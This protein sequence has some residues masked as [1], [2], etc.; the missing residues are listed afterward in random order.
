MSVLKRPTLI[1]SPLADLHELAAELALEGYRKLRKEDLVSAILRS[2]GIEDDG[3]A[4]SESVRDERADGDAAGGRSR[5]DG[6]RSRASGPRE[7]PE[8]PERSSRRGERPAER[9][10]GRGERPAERGDDRAERIA[11][12][13]VELSGNGSG[14]L[15]VADGEDV[16]ISAAQVRRCELVDGDEVTGPVR[17]ARRSERHPSLARVHSIN[18]APSEEVAGAV[19]FEELAVE[20]PSERLPIAGSDPVLAA[21]DAAVPIGKGSRVTICGAPHAGKS[22]L[23]REYGAALAAV[24]GLSVAIVLA[25]VRPEEIADWPQGED[26]PETSISSDS[27]PDVQSA[28]VW[29]AVQTGRRVAARGGDAVVLIDSLEALPDGTARRV[30][31]SARKLQAGGSLT[32][33]AT[34]SAPVGLETSIIALD[35]AKRRAGEDPVD[36]GGS[37]TIA[38]DRLVAAKP[39]AKRAARKPAAAKK[40]AAKRKP[41][42]KKKAAAKPPAADD[43]GP[44]AA[45]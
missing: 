39:A 17:P 34:A 4:E 2:Q 44:D 29:S 10:A 19:R 43:G 31:G 30:L 12:G 26:G 3:P 11:T 36:R 20:Y 27:P 38:S 25:G 33:I 15:R 45:S 22:H 13:T 5:R 37:G 18:G 35:V 1:A 16:Y 9:S 42:A 23:L 6:R 8:R 14:L 41:A 24:D 28:A 7:R 40:P 32:V 21:A